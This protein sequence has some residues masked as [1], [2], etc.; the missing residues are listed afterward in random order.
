M[1]DQKR[2]SRVVFSSNFILLRFTAE[3]NLSLF[4]SNFILFGFT[5]EED[6]SSFCTN[7]FYVS[8]F[9]EKNIY[10]PFALSASYEECR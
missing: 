6:L 4:F 5:A 9:Y 10:F 1:L 3:E 8:L 7:R 2:D